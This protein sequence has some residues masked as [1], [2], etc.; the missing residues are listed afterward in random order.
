M[1]DNRIWY[2]CTGYAIIFAPLINYG[3][4]HITGRW[5]P[6][7]YMYIFAGC[8]TIVWSLVIYFFLPPDPIRAKGFTERQRYI[9]VA[10]LQQNNSGVRNTHFKASQAI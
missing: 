3:L 6:W 8:L 1:F 10:R 5:S 9:A 2:C 4:G 7:R